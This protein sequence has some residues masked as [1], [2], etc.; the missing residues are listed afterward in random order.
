MRIA[1][2]TGIPNVGR[3]EYI[4]AA[5]EWGSKQNNKSAERENVSQN[6]DLPLGGESGALKIEMKMYDLLEYMKRIDPLIDEE[7]V[8][9]IPEERLNAVRLQAEE[10]VSNEIE[11][12]KNREFSE[13]R[14]YIIFVLTRAVFQSY[15][16]WK[17]SPEPS[18]NADLYINITS[19]IAD[20]VTNFKKDGR[21]KNNPRFSYLK[22]GSDN[23]EPK[24][25]DHWKNLTNQLEETPTDYRNLQ[26]EEQDRD[27]LNFL[28]DWKNLEYIETKSWADARSKPF[29]LILRHYNDKI[30]SNENSKKNEENLKTLYDLVMNE[31]PRLY[32]SYPMEYLTSSE[33]DKKKHSDF[34]TAL[35]SMYVV[36]D[37][38][39]T[40][41]INNITGDICDVDFQLIKQ[42]DFV[43]VRYI[44]KPIVDNGDK[45]G[46]IVM[47]AGVLS[48]MQYAATLGRKVFAVWE[49]Q[50]DPSV[51]FRRWCWKIYRS[52]DELLKAIPKDCN[53]KGDLRNQGTTP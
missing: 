26:K 25:Q 20:L 49:P 9:N 34:I 37:P 44:K 42:S 43:I 51:F 11:N 5:I 52:V 8:L 4:E 3:R 6:Y 36:F 30:N 18:I 53:N 45:G 46:D 16:V 15:Y 33:E 41:P 48:E 28:Q 35:R 17:K 10:T 13:H 7:T 39:N 47:S 22:Y 50:K 19:K 29:F 1:I 12:L 27:I 2:V 31:K 24:D 40:Y 32:L 23:K 21:F 38:I 14:E